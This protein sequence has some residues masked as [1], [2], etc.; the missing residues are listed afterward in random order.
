MVKIFATDDEQ[1]IFRKSLEGMKTNFLEIL[2]GQEKNMFYFPTAFSFSSRIGE[3]ETCVPDALDEMKLSL[4][5]KQL[6]TPKDE[7]NLRKIRENLQKLRPELAEQEFVDALA[8]FF[9]RQRGVFIHSLKFDDH[10]KVLTNKAREYRRQN[11]SIG[12][13]LTDFEKKLTEKLNISIQ[14]LIYIADIVVNHLLTKPK[15]GNRSKINGKVVRDSIDEKLKGNNRMYVMK[16]IKPAKDYSIDEVRDGVILGKFESECRV[17]GENDLFLMLPDSKIIL[18]VEIKR[19]MK[20]KPSSSHIENNMVSASQQLKKNAQFIASKHGSILSPDWRFAKI[21][22]IYPRVYNPDK[23]CSSCKKFILTTDMIKAPGGL[24]K[25][26]KETGISELDNLFDQNSKHEAYQEFQPFFNRMI[27]MSSVRVVADHSNT[28]AQV[29][30][31]KQ[32]QHMSVGGTEA[33]QGM[34]KKAAADDLDFEDDVLKA[35]Y[36]AYRSFSSLKIRWSC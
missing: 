26:W 22:A 25:W 16:L 17:S 12:F 31:N 28:W 18:C 4:E 29:Q 13:Q 5:C 34:S 35:P 33:P 9:Y 2:E 21:C 11:K 30:G 10:L 23:I 14:I 7:R 3:D 6:L 24:N 15:A 32:Y 20:C 36:H 19:H 8:C 27:C 1:R